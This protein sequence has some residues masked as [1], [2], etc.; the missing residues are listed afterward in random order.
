MTAS[1][2]ATRL[3]QI[4][5]EA[6]TGNLGLRE[7]ADARSIRREGEPEGRWGPLDHSDVAVH[8]QHDDDRVY[9]ALER[10][11]KERPALPLPEDINAHAAQRVRAG[12][13]Q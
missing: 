3:V 12:E 4:A 9:Y 11:R 8:I 1:D 7:D 2:K 10:L 6:A 5:A 13:G